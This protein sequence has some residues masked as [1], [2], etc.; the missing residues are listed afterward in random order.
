[1]CRPEKP[2]NPSWD[3][4]RRHHLSGLLKNSLKGGNTHEANGGVAAS[5]S[6]SHS[7]LIVK[8]E[9]KKRWTEQLR[10]ISLWWK[11]M[12]WSGGVEWF[13]ASVSDHLSGS[14]QNGRQ[15]EIWVCGFVCRRE[16]ER[17]GGAVLCG[18]LWQ[19]SS[20][21]ALAGEANVLFCSQWVC[22]GSTAAPSEN[23]CSGPPSLFSTQGAS[24]HSSSFCFPNAFLSLLGSEPHLIHTAVSACFATSGS[25]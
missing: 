5:L 2:A 21:A 6:H 3:I 8:K 4:L 9:K 20:R 1:M 7:D 16:G 25:H 10:R 13:E 22:D 11:S 19:E 14:L 17:W 24:L 18:W 23:I 12:Q 15:K